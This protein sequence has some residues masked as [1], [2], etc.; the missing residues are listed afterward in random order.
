M[1]RGFVKWFNS[2]K[3]Y[4]FVCPEE[5][6]GIDIFAH[7]SSILMDGYKTLK[8]GQP[9]EYDLHTGPKGIHAT[10]IRLA[11]EAPSEEPV[12]SHKTTEECAS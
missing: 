1:A 5:E 8:A 4:G 12:R 11:G 10:N 3:G 7:F 6:E 2:A 9:V